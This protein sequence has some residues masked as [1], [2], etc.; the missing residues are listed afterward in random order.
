M[1]SN[2]LPKCARGTTP[3]ARAADATRQAHPH[4]F[5]HWG[6][7]PRRNSHSASPTAPHAHRVSQSAISHGG[8]RASVLGA[9][10]QRAGA[11]SS[12]HRVPERSFDRTLPPR[13]PAGRRSSGSF[14]SFDSF[15]SEEGRRLSDVT[16]DSLLESLEEKDGDSSFEVNLMRGLIRKLRQRIAL[17][18]LAAHAAEQQL[19]R[20]MRRRWGSLWQPRMSSRRALQRWASRCGLNLTARQVRQPA[21]LPHSGPLSPLVA[22][23]HVRRVLSAFSASADQLV[24]WWDYC[25]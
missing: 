7:F 3:Q 9:A 13:A 24:D 4:I 1:C 6:A 14:R 22:T 8:F 23:L 5:S 19:R 25:Q 2:P 21:A 16:V 18:A 10:C 11:P 20:R 12:K 17:G 15:A